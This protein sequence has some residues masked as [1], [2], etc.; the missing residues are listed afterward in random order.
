ML[1]ARVYRTAFLPA[2]VALFVA[3]FALA[4]RPGPARSGLPADAFS[5]ARAFGTG[6]APEPQSLQGMAAAFPDRAARGR[7]RTTAWPTSSRA[8]SRR[9]TSAASARRSACAGP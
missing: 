4:D 9:R 8:C 5:G 3:A 6:D 2:L 1:D 7:P